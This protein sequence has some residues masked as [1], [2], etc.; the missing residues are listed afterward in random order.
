MI[1]ILNK[2]GMPDEL[3]AGSLTM[4]QPATFYSL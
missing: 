1:D 4:N 3:F 2:N